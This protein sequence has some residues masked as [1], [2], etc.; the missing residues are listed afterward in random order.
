MLGGELDERS[1]CLQP[2]SGI[3]TARC[4]PGSRRSTYTLETLDE[5]T[6]LKCVVT[7]SNAAGQASAQSNAVTIPIPKV[8]AVPGCDRLDDRHHD[9]SDQRWG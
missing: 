8:A 2:T 9:R 3:A 1:N 5:G 6:T 4:W 7:A